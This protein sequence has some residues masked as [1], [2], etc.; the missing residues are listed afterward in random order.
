MISGERKIQIFPNGLAISELEAINNAIIELSKIKLDNSIIDELNVLKKQF[1]KQDEGQAKEQAKIIKE[2][3]L[4]KVEVRNGINVIAQ[5]ISLNDAAAIKDLAFQLKAQIENLYL[6][7]GA[8]VN[9]KPN[10]IV[11]LSDNLLKDKN[12]HAGNIVREAAKEMQ[13]GGGGQ[14]FYATAG[15]NNLAGL[16]AAIA[17]ALSFLN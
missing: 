5:K 15:G 7:L 10:L 1:Q 16:D 2:K 6:V 4:T 9:G 11:A 17:K 12:L 8:E 13:G 14:P 3:L